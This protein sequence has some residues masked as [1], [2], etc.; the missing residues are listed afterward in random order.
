MGS[1][2]CIRDSLEEL[3]SL[4]M[5]PGSFDLIVSNCVI[6]LCTDKPAVLSAAHDLLRSGGEMYFSDVYAD[7]RIPEDLAKDPLLYGECL[8]G[9]LYWNDFENMAKAAGFPDPRLV[10]S[11]PLAINNPQIAEKLGNI[12]F[13]SATYRL[14]RIDSL[15]PACEDYG[16]AVKYL[17][18]VPHHPHRLELDGHHH[19]E[20]GRVFP[21]CGNSYR[22]LNESRFRDHFEF[23]GNWD[24]HLG[25][26]PGCGTELPYSNT[27]TN[28]SQEST[29]S[30]AC[31]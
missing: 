9:A 5:D 19:F 11:R 1:E 23:F 16:Q 10:E 30:G 24:Q 4:G 12:R 14:F 18:T 25:I 21:V 7:R 2:M 29:N 27:E 17:G 15:E 28:D 6:N 3:A 8:A 26:F 22:M 31:C 13:Y 20:T